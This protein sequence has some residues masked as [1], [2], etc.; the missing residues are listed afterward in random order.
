MR[1]NSDVGSQ[2][3]IHGEADKKRL[4]EA[5]KKFM[6]AVEKSRKQNRRD[7]EKQKFTV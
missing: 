5:T 3:R 6:Q 4:L 2:V 1:K 7:Y